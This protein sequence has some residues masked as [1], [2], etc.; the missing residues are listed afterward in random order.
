MCWIIHLGN[1]ALFFFSRKRY[2]QTKRRYVV[3][4]GCVLIQFIGIALPSTML[5]IVYVDI[6]REF[7][8]DASQAA[9]M[10]SL[11]RGISFGG[12]TFNSESVRTAAELSLYKSP[13]LKGNF[14]KII[15]QGYTLRKYRKNPFNPKDQHWET[16]KNIKKGYMVMEMRIW[17]YIEVSIGFDVY[18]IHI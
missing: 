5:G 18:Y 11:F 6:T 4:V 16:M 10:L 17:R 7:R 3:F 9:L 13:F 8:T 12:G 14:T 2:Y 1:A 15:W